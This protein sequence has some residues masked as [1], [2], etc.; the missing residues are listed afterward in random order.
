M[1]E[2]Q[3]NE[4]IKENCQ[5][6]RFLSATSSKCDQLTKENSTLNSSLQELRSLSLFLII[7]FCFYFSFLGK[8]D[9]EKFEFLTEIDRLKRTIEILQRDREIKQTRISD[10]ELKKIHSVIR[11][12]EHQVLSLIFFI[13]HFNEFNLNFSVNSR[14]RTKSNFKS[15][16]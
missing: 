10:D 11:N 15:R 13:K 1:T 3:L 5:T 8:F 14:T 2:G 12:L 16:N 9:T 4:M 7:R 6:N